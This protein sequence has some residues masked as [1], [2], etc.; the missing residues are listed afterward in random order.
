MRAPFCKSVRGENA[1]HGT[2]PFRARSSFSWHVFRKG[3][4]S[5][6]PEHT[7]ANHA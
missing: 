2:R 7:G 4:Q 1:S 5:R 6:P 3:G